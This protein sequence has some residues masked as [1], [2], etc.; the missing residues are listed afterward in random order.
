MK[1][2]ILLRRRLSGKSRNGKARSLEE[3]I[4]LEEMDA[5]VFPEGTHRYEGAYGT[6]AVHVPRDV[7]LGDIERALTGLVLEAGE[8][9]GG[10]V[11]DAA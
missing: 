8:S 11:E 4:L 9:D 3:V 7:T 2:G 1:R 5:V 10:G 6:A